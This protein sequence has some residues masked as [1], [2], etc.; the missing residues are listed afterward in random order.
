MLRV[1]RGWRIVRPRVRPRLARTP[2]ELVDRQSLPFSKEHG[3][4]I[5]CGLVSISPC[6]FLRIESG[7]ET[8]DWVCLRRY[9]GECPVRFCKG[10]A[11]DDRSDPR[12]ALLP[13]LLSKRRDRPIASSLNPGLLGMPPNRSKIRR[14]ETPKVGVTCENPSLDRKQ[15]TSPFC[16]VCVRRRSGLLG[17]GSAV[18]ANFQA[19]YHDPEPAVFFYLPL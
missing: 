13:R 1:S 19:R 6:F 12:A 15:P 16:P 8:L 14:G 3:E 10:G 7:R 9:D 2:E 5:K 18:A 11:L 4:K 17:T